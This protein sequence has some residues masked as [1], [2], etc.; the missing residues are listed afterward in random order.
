MPETLNQLESIHS[1]SKI[2]ILFPSHCLLPSSLSPSSTSHYM[3]MINP[4][5]NLLPHIITDVNPTL[6][7]INQHKQPQPTTSTLLP[8]HLPTSTPPSPWAPERQELQHPQGRIGSQEVDVDDVA[9]FLQRSDGGQ[10]PMMGIACCTANN[11][12]PL[13]WHNITCYHG[14]ANDIGITNIVDQVNQQPTIL[15]WLITY[16]T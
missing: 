3:S 10:L 14:I 4:T 13:V 11:Q 8:P 5:I 9:M 12:Q 2:I 1:C 15:V 6:S 16:V 7:N